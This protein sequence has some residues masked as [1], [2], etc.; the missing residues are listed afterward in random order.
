[1][2]RG[3]KRD[4]PSLVP[5]EGKG[6]ANPLLK[7]S[8]RK[9]GRG[10]GSADNLEKKSASG[11]SEIAREKKRGVSPAKGSRQHH[12]EP[13]RVGEKRLR[14]DFAGHVSA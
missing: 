13:N 3:G 5:P 6:G 8:S 12:H 7:S 11:G 2:E 9:R 4:S 10:A 14:V 1:L